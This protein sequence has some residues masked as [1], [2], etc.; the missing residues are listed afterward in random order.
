MKATSGF[1]VELL[2]GLRGDVLLDPADETLAA[3]L[4]ARGWRASA[5]V[6]GAAPEPAR[7]A[8]LLAPCS[9]LVGRAPAPALLEAARAGGVPHHHGLPD[10]LAPRPGALPAYAF[11]IGRLERDFVQA[12]EALRAAVLRE[13][14]LPL[15]WI[16]DGRHRC[17]VPGVREATRQM[18]RHA[19]FVV[20]DLTLGVESPERENPSRAHEIGISQALDK[21]LLLTSQEP[22]RHPYYSIGDMQMAFWH[23]EQELHAHACNWI[24]RHREQVARRL[25]PAPE[26]PF[27]Y[28]AARRFV[29]PNWR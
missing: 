1:V 17:N 8:R 14:G 10:T 22:R 29:G 13:A 25:L 7:A 12:R 19:V 20:A 15:L 4:A 21:P 23:D 2:D 9:A 11:F 24:L 28:D 16:D 3:A 6:E 26:A 18:I 27:H 5:D